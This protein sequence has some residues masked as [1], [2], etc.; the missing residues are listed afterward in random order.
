MKKKQPAL[1]LGLRMVKGLS[2]CG[3]ETLLEV[4]REEP[5]S[6]MQDLVARAALNSRDLESLAAADALQELA[7][8]RH[9][10]WWQVSGSEPALPLFGAPR[11]P[12]AEPLLRS[13]SE[14]EQIVADYAATGLSLR[15]HPLALLRERLQARGIRKAEELWALGNGEHA[16]AAG[17]VLV[18]QRPGSASGVIF[19]TLED[20]SGTVNVVVWPSFAEAQRQALLKARL[21]A[22][23]GTIQQESGVLHLIAGRLEDLSSWLG[24]LEASSRDFH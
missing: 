14:G 21:L 12:E 19:V 6:D 15:R 24:E 9:R 17:L 20:E 13:P 5:F 18:R 2:R 7:G 10:A 1:R 8:H 3:A 4:R 23:T 16:K 22:V 11:F